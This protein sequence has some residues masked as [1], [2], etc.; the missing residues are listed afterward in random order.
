MAVSPLAIP[1]MVVVIPHL[2]MKKLME[3]RLTINLAI[4]YNRIK[5]A[6]VINYMLEI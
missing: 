1:E 4:T 2:Q 5:L 6:D 3:M